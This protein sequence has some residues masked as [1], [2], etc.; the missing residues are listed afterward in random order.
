MKEHNVPATFFLIGVSANLNPDIVRQEFEQGHEIG[1]HTYS[2]PD[3]TEISD[4]QLDFEL[5]ATQRLISGILGRKTILFRPPFAEDIE[6]ETPDQINPL[7][8]TNK[9]GYYTVAMHIDPK[10]WSSPGP[11]VIIERTLESAKRGDGNIVLL[12]DGGGD[13]EQTVQSL[14]GIIT[15]LREQGFEI[16]SVA[17]LIG[18]DRD[19][20]M[21]KVSTNE[22]IITWS[23]SATIFLMDWFNRFM[24][25]TFFVGI[26]LG[27]MRFLFIGT[28]A[29]IQWVHSRHGRFKEYEHSYCPTVGVIIPAYNEEK[30]IIRT[31]KAILSSSYSKIDIVV[32][33]DGSNDQTYKKTKEYFASDS[34]VRTFTKENEGKSEALN[35]GILKTDAEIIV[36]LDADTIFLPDTIKK[37]VRKF[38]D[39]KIWAVAG[40]AKV[41]NRI[42]ILTRWQ[43]LEYI[44]SQNLDR[45]AFEIMNC[46]NVVPGA[47]GAWR[48]EAILETG[49]FSSDTLAE[50]ADLTFSIIKN[51]HRIAYEDQALAFT[52]APD[53]TRNFVK[54]RFRW[55]YGTLQ[56]VWKHRE[57]WFRKKYGALGLFSIPN[58]LTFQ[59]IFPLVSPLMDLMMILSILWATWQNHYHPIDFSSAQSFQKIFFFYV[60]F[61][62]IDLLTA[63]IP[64]ILERKENWTLIVWLPLQRFYYRQLMYYVAIKAIFTILRGRMVGWGKFERKATV[65]EA[66]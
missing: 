19:V 63:I 52:E 1:S 49:G 10:D 14:P 36:T 5:G 28:L 22:K 55:M 17:N 24:R 37:L 56:T 2:H 8:F 21:P 13:R 27:T 45:R 50:D 46:I 20:L 32:V 60:S 62:I 59:I 51:G 26:V 65:K 66:A 47:I 53:S 31:I 25:L 43:A 38:V 4:K 30:V 18:T 3:I 15:G 33:D 16:V 7:V 61:L 12:H 41:G 23:G 44:V 29:I 57:I 6:P 40:N 9:S 48:K 35:F 54:Q 39:K 11:E 42:N 64:F 34:R 58:V